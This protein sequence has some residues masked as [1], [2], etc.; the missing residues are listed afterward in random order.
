[1]STEREQPPVR[2]SEW[3]R[4][5]L[6]EALEVYRHGSDPRLKPAGDRLS[7]GLADVLAWSVLWRRD[8]HRRCAPSLTG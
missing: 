2:V 1:M 5:A 3:W 4:V 6:W 8:D 7:R